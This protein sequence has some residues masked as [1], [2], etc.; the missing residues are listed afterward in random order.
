M[1]N[2]YIKNLRTNYKKML[3]LAEMLSDNIPFLR[4]DFYEINKKIYLQLK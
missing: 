3:Q 2:K 1:E 4:V